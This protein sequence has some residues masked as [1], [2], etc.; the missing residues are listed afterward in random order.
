M[1]KTIIRKILYFLGIILNLRI[2]I[3]STDSHYV[4]EAFQIGLQY[5][6]MGISPLLVYTGI[7]G[8]GLFYTFGTPEQYHYIWNLY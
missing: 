5:R 7:N 6:Y 2:R 3:R 1:T 4:N 8:V